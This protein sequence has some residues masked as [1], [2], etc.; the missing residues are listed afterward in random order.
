MH[1]H[2]DIQ[3]C[4][5]CLLHPFWNHWWSLPSEWLLEV[6]F[7]PES[8]YFF[9]KSHLFPSQWERNTKTKQPIRFQGLFT[10]TNQI[11][12]KFLSV[13]HTKGDL[14]AFALFCKPATGSINWFQNQTLVPFLNHV[15]D[16]RPNCTPLNSTF[17]IINKFYVQVFYQLDQLYIVSV[18]WFFLFLDRSLYVVSL[19]STS[20]SYTSLTEFF[21]PL[22][23]VMTLFISKPALEACEL[24]LF[25]ALVLLSDLATNLHTLQWNKYKC[26]KSVL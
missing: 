25:I 9:S 22:L 19:C 14:K 5:I 3:W 15:Y 11:A 16:F 7:I 17:T 6:Q 20:S 4:C 8:H 26:T 10:V 18:L 12:G 13:L 1:Q 23:S 21:A 2:C 24:F